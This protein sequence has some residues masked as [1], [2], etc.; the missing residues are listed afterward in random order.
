VGYPN[1]GK[2][3]VINAV[4]F[5]HKA[6]VSSKA[7]TTHGVHWIS[8]GKEIKFIDTPGVIPI[9][10]YVDEARLGIIAAKNPEKLKDPEAV[11]TI[12]I[13]KF[14]EDEKISRFEELYR[15]KIPEEMKQEKNASRILEFL[16]IEKHHLKKGGLPDETRTA[17]NLVK[18]WQEGKLKL[19]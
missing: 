15:I 4:G 2:S 8:A 19:K 3:S 12:I 14:L 9:G 7:G 18:D 11:A 6:I 5:T 10:S 17:L 1:V 13:N 16:S